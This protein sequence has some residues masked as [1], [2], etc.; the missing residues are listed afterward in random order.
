MEVF[1]T[2]ETGKDFGTCV[3]AWETWEDSLSHAE[4]EIVARKGTLD[5]VQALRNGDV[6][7]W[8]DDSSYRITIIGSC[9]VEAWG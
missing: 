4:H 2:L 7:S 1:I 5:E 9:D 3:R 6:D 8:G